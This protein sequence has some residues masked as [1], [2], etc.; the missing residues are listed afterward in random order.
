MQRLRSLLGFGFIVLFSAVM[1]FAQ[2]GTIAGTVSDASWAVVQGAEITVRNTATNETHQTTSGS[3]GT[4]T[5]T[6]LPVGSYEITV[7]KEGFKVYRLPSIELTVAQSLTVDPRLSTGA[8]NEEVT[9]R[10]DRMQDLDLETAQISNLVDQ[11]ADG[12]LAADHA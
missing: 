4:Y 2:T 6:N 7:K 1:S 9:V 5:V 8:A 11:R 12:G 3:A 10:A